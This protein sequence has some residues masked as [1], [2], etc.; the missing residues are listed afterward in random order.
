MS[1]IVQIS[2]F[3]HLCTLKIVFRSPLKP[4]HEGSA[5]DM[6]PAVKRP[7]TPRHKLCLHVILYL[8]TPPVYIRMGLVSM[9]KVR[10]YWEMTTR[11]S[12]IADK[13]SRKRFGK[14]ADSL[15]VK[16]NLLVTEQE[17]R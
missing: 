6:L 10:Y 14:L 7:Q 15:H 4:P 12:A 2:P 16:N 5:L 8:A 17:K 11:Y 9:P 13:M 3:V 1:F